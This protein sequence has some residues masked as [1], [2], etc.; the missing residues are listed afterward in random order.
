MNQSVT[1]TTYKLITSAI[2]GLSWSNYIPTYVFSWRT[3]LEK[4]LCLKF[5]GRISLANSI[6]SHTTKLSPLEPHEMTE[7][8]AGSST[9]SKVLHKNGGIGVP[10]KLSSGRGI[11]PK[12]SA[13]LILASINGDGNCEDKFTGKGNGWSVGWIDENPEPI[14]VSESDPGDLGEGLSWGFIMS[15]FWVRREEWEKWEE[16][17][18]WK[19]VI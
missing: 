13:S 16:N 12:F 19:I 3:K 15:W 1:R 17:G 18:R 6:G 2:A 14:W 9:R 8:T 5:L 4:L 7:S 11:S 10:C